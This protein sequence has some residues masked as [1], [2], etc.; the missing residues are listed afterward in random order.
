MDELWQRERLSRFES[1]ASG[2]W[3]TVYSTW[4]EANANGA[5][6]SAFSPGRKRPQVLS[7][8]SW[9]LSIG[10]GMPGFIEY[11][12][13]KG[14]RTRYLRYGD[15]NGIEPL[16][17][18]QS[19]YGARPRMLPQI[20]EEFRLYHNLWLAR[21]GTK[22]YK[23]NN[24]GTEE[25]AA[26]ISDDYVRIRT[27]LLRQF[28]AGRQLDLLLFIDS[29]QYVDD[30]HERIDLDDISDELADDNRRISLY[31]SD[32]A[33]GAKRPFSRLIGKRLIKPPPRKRAGIAPFDDQV[34]V[35]PEFIIGETSEGDLVRHTCDPEGLKNNFG[36][37][38]DAHHYL[39]PVY[40]R[41]EVLQRYYERPEKYAVEDGYL[42]CVG[43]WGVRIDNDH[44]Q[45]V[46]VW[47][48][49]LGRDLPSSERSY[50]QTFNIAHG[51][52]S[53][54][55]YRRAIQGEFAD[56]QAPDLRFKSKYPRFRRK[57]RDQVGWDL[58]REPQQEDEH[59][60]ARLRI[61]LNDSQPEFEDQ[62]LGLTKVLVD[63]LHEGNLGARLPN[64]IA[65]EKGIGKLERWLTL[66]KYPYV[67]RD[68][69]FLRRLQ[70]LR[71]EIVAHGK[72]SHYRKLLEKHQVDS[73]TTREMII[74]FQRAELFLDSLA[75]Q[76]GIDLDRY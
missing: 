35:Y 69:E 32:H 61:P 1:E 16:V 67:E 42:R 65:N 3:V 58:Y 18:C 66:E 47:L 23:L 13:Q 36:K 24:D 33:Y 41:R 17:I 15:D 11:W 30:P 10:S 25:I 34:E 72:G 20:S 9:D 59:V 64:K 73:D 49:D 54:T 38:P 48:G 76:F 44:P 55:A 60:F 29:V 57:W 28:Q 63:W 50:W 26:E 12:G 27:K 62:V 45:H 71:S 39:T 46:M 37:N 52:L 74:M 8:D 31:A 6:F 43:L 14:H 5:Q 70:N 4:D 2:P 56:P 19:H 7:S 21:D 22:A 75:S 68:I 53:S 40:F 51:S